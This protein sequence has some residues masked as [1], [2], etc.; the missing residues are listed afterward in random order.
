MN[1][2]DIPAFDEEDD[3]DEPVS[4]EEFRSIRGDLDLILESLTNQGGKE[5]SQE[6]ETHLSLV[7]EEEHLLCRNCKQ[8]K[9]AS[10]FSDPN[11]NKCRSCQSKYSRLHSAAKRLDVDTQAQVLAIK[12]AAVNVE[13]I[14]RVM[15][16][17]V[18][19]HNTQ[20][21]KM[22]KLLDKIHNI[23]E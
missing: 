10:N 3:N 16:T 11:I 9:P 5:E 21:V 13:R 14:Q 4:R 6:E 1:K 19:F 22:Q 7:S 2:L 18:I 23:P 12:D 17:A 15:Q 8:V 20:A